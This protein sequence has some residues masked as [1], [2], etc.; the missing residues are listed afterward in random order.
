MKLK[1]IAILTSLLLAGGLYADHH[2]GKGGKHNFEKMARY[3]ELND[4]QKSKLK[5]MHDAHRAQMKQRREAMRAQ[6]KKVREM[7]RQDEINRSAIKAELEKA[8]AMHVEKRMAMIDHRLEVEKIL[9]DE[10]KKKMREMMKKRLEKHY[11]RKGGH[12]RY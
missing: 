6:K 2:K 10:Q 11:K 8:A 9:N 1:T 4:D 12:D 5:K 7:L 3:L